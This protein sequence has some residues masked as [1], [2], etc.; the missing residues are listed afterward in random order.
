VNNSQEEFVGADL[1]IPPQSIEA[2]SCVLGSL[3]LRNESFDVIGDLLTGDHFYTHSHKLIFNAIKALV[4]R[5]QPADVVT[6]NEYLCSVGQGE[7][8][9]LEYI[10]S[11]AQ[12]VPSASNIRRYAEIVRERSILRALINAGDS[13]SASAYAPNGCLVEELL[14]AAESQIAQIQETGINKDGV[15]TLDQLALEFMDRL[16]EKADHP[17]LQSGTKTGF[18]DLDNSTGGLQEGDLIVIA[19]RPSMGKTALAMNIAED[20]AI[21]QGLPVLVISLE[22]NAAAL[23]QRIVGSVGRIDQ[24]KLRD[25]TLD[26]SDWP[27]VCDAIERVKGKTLDVLDVGGGTI[28]AIRTVARQA[29]KRHKKLGLI[30]VD[31]IQLM[32]GDSDSNNENRTTEVSGISRGLKRLAKEMQCPLIALSQ[33]NR[34]VENRADKR[35]LMSDLRESGAIEQDAD[36]IMF[37]YRDDYYTKEASKEPGVA[38]IIIAK[39]RNGPTGVVRLDWESS[40]TKFTNR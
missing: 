19:G 25:G 3:L 32:D 4:G 40:M 9:G 1:R 27:R 23:M 15:Q 17:G 39:Q 35:P 11:L 30:V 13:I 28:S 24:T 2:E 10:N 29:R 26:D 20:A 22:M 31:Y 36:I 7:S 18:L 33:L 5:A 6:V 14:V 8:I 34:S 37:I 38:E 21:E 12:Y 16:Q